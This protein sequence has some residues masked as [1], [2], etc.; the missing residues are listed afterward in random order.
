M[1]RGR[2]PG[3]VGPDGLAAARAGQVV[4]AGRRAVGGQH[5]E[6]H[7][8]HVQ[9]AL[10]RRA[11]QVEVVGRQRAEGVDAGQLDD[12]AVVGPREERRRAGPAGGV[13]SAPGHGIALRVELR[14]VIRG[15]PVVVP[16]RR[17]SLAVVLHAVGATST[18]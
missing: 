1:I 14:I 11:G 6:L 10:D 2:R 7:Q 9:A 8:V 4:P 18:S 13:G 12:V 15:D 3:E 16:S 17:A 5:V